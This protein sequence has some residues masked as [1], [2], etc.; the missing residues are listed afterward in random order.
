MR[1]L[2][3]DTF[4]FDYNP[5]LEDNRKYKIAMHNG[6]TETIVNH[7]LTNEIKQTAYT[8]LNRTRTRAPRSLTST[9]SHVILSGAYGDR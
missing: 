6:I 3:L 4:L 2:L 5:Y 7:H 8:L 9:P 1:L